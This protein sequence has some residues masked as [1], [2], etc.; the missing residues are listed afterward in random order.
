MKK[1]ILICIIATII[2]LIMLCLYGGIGTSLGI[3]FLRRIEQNYKIVNDSKTI[4]DDTII[5]NHS[6]VEDSIEVVEIENTNY[7]R[8]QLHEVQYNYYHNSRFDYSIEYPSCF[9]QQEEPTN[10]DGCSFY[11]NERIYLS[12]FASYNALN[13]T[14][15]DRYYENAISTVA[16]S[17]LKNNWFVISDYTSDGRIFYQKTVLKNDIFMTAILCYPPEYK[18][19]FQKITQRIFSKFSICI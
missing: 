5:T 12:V 2:S 15:A 11:M 14:I 13:E 16:Y 6:E 4:T 7:I 19:D 1:T 10:G 18:N 17:T 3:V 9:I 8:T